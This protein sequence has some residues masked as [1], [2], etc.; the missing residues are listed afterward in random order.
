M[1]NKTEKPA[2]KTL[3]EDM[4]VYLLPATALVCVNEHSGIFYGVFTPPGLDQS[5]TSFVWQPKVHGIVS[6]GDC[7]QGEMRRINLSKLPNV[8]RYK[9]VMR[10]D[11][12]VEL[13]EIYNIDIAEKTCD[14][15]LLCGENVLDKAYRVPCEIFFYVNG[16]K[17][18]GK[19]LIEA[20]LDAGQFV[21]DINTEVIYGGKTY[22]SVSSHDNATVNTL[23]ELRLFSAK[24]IKKTAMKYV[25]QKAD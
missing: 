11:K 21:L 7:V 10:I 20:S 2:P 4:D 1:E 15:K 24:E 19:D 9:Y 6:V 5:Y 3:F 12:R 16:F 23:E 25:K 22:I 18:D 8:C 14:F 13:A 17:F